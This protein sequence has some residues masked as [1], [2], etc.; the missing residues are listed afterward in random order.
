MIIFAGQKN[1]YGWLQGVN[2]DVEMATYY[3]SQRNDYN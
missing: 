3:A 1:N 2:T